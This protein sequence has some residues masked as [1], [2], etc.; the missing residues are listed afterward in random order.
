LIT[1]ES[2]NGDA[3]VWKVSKLFV[4]GSKGKKSAGGKVRPMRERIP[5]G[6]KWVSLLVCLAC[7]FGEGKS[8]ERVSTPW[9]ATA[10]KK[11][12]RSDKQA[13][14]ARRRRAEV[15]LADGICAMVSAWVLFYNPKAA[16]RVRA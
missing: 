13:S 5:G 9:A 8:A 11:Q 7:A 4:P 6:F 15:R 3:G 2:R 12:L 16:S 10:I 1:S 14:A